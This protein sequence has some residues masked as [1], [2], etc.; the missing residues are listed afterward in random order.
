MPNADGI[1]ATA[2]AKARRGVTGL[3][4]SFIGLLV[5]ILFLFVDLPARRW[6]R[7]KVGNR[8]LVSRIAALIF[9][10]IL[11][12]LVIYIIIISNLICRE[13]LADTK[14]ISARE[15]C[16]DSRLDTFHHLAGKRKPGR[17]V[18]LFVCSIVLCS[19]VQSLFKVGWP[20][21]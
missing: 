8:G 9:V 3:I 15:S 14:P 18:I 7:S 2:G 17:R 12:F 13:P 4:C 11:Y 16:R 5:V 19:W 20:S 6:R 1:R 10:F 21:G